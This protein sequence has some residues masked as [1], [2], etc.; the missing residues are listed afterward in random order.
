M[1][2][3]DEILKS[4]RANLPRLDRPLPEVRM[5]DANTPTSLLAAFKAGLERMAIRVGLQA[6]AADRR[7]TRGSGGD[8]VERTRP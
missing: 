8:E 5:F 3:R 4:I 7:Q 1:S 6:S 2:N